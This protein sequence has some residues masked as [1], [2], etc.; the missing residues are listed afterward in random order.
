MAEGDR[1]VGGDK[2]GMF[3]VVPVRGELIGRAD[4]QRISVE[5]ERLGRLEP[6][7]KRLFRQVVARVIEK[8]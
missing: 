7:A 1:G 8:P 2:V 5:T 6:G 3:G 4:D